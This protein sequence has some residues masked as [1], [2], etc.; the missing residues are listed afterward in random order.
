MTSRPQILV[1]LSVLFVTLS[2]AAEGN[3]SLGIAGRQAP[4]WDLEWLNLPETYGDLSVEDFRGKVLVVFCFQSWCPGC[5]SHGFPAMQEIEQHF[6]KND[7][8]QMVAIQT[9]FE[10]FGTNTA[11][12]ALEEVETY[13]LE[14]PVAHDAGDN[15][16]SPF[17]RA[18]RTGGTPWTI[19]I[20]PAGKVVWNGFQIQ[21]Q[22]AIS[23]IDRLLT[24]SA[25]QSP[26]SGSAAGTGEGS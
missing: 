23:A 20:D 11:Y 7:D 19:V 6:R 8:V 15:G 24:E 16:L 4:A 25:R 3:R 12:R 26:P 1:A 13:G 22:Q 17:M 2:V 21:P 10:G 5:H 14:I 9:V 18:Y